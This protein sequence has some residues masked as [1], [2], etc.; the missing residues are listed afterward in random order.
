MQ[1]AVSNKNHHHETLKT[2]SGGAQA[3]AEPAPIMSHALLDLDH[4]HV[5]H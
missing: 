2:Q 3:G 4:H 1:P 5:T